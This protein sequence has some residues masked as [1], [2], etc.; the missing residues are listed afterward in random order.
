[1]HT[2]LIRAVRGRLTN[3][4]DTSGNLTRRLLEPT[5]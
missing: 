2:L 5:P 4:T 3:A 1:M